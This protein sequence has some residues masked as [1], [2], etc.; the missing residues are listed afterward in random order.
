MS[1]C[2]SWFTPADLVLE[3]G[4]GVEGGRRLGVDRRRLGLGGHADGGGG[5]LFLVVGL[6][7]LGGGGVQAPLGL[8]GLLNLNEKKVG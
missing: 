8:Q 3:G 2:D 6:V 1:F 7:G 4:V 5:G